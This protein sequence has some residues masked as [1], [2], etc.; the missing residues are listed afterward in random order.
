MMTTMPLNE[1]HFVLAATAV[2]TDAW[3]L[4]NAYYYY[5]CYCY[6]YYYYYYY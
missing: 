2:A 1:I 5:Y 6:Y 4:I 3:H